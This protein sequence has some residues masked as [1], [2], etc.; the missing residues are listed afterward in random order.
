MKSNLLL[1][2][3]A[4]AKRA[5]CLVALLNFLST[6][7]MAKD[8]DPLF[9]YEIEK[10]IIITGQIT[11]E[12][13]T[14][15]AGVNIM[16]KGTSNGVFSD[17]DGKFSIKV[18][19]KNSSLIF[20]FVGYSIKEIKIGSQSNFNVKLETISKD[21]DDVVVVGYGTQKRSELTNAVV[22]ASGK[23]L[24]KSNSISLSN[25][26]SG[27]LAGVFVNQRSSVP[28]FDDAQ[29]LVRGPNTYRNSSALI[30]IDGV[31]NA[32]PDGLNRLDP[33]DIE[34]ISVLKDASA[35]IYGAQSAGGV[36]LVTTKR[37]KTGKPTFDFVTTQS[38]N[39]PTMK[40]KSADAF[41]YM[42]VLNDRRALEGTPPDFPDELVQEFKTGKRRPE[43]W[44]DALVDPPAK[45]ARYSL[46]MRG[47]TDRVRYFLSLGTANQGGILRG[48]DKTRLK[49]YNVR[50][51]VD[52][53]VTKDLEVGLDISLR[54]KYTQT[55]Q[56]GPGGNIEYFANTSP[57]QEAYIGGDYRYPGEGWSQ[58]NPAARLLSPGYRKY[59]AD[60]ASGTL[61]FKYNIP[62][63]KGLALDGFA[64][65]VKTSNYNKSFN[66]TWFY[67]E[68]NPTT[69]DI[70][71]KPSRTVEDI[72][73][74]EEYYQSQR[75][76]GNLKLS[77][78]TVI[79]KD[80]KISVFA[81]YEQMEYKDNNFWAQRL[82]YDSYM[83][84]Q[85]FAGSKN[86][87][88]GS[89]S[90]TASES[91]RQNYFG[92]ASYE[93][94][95]KYLLGFSA[96]YDGSPIFP[97]D[98]RFGFFPQASAAWVVSKESFM[99]KSP[100]SNLKVRASWGQLGNDRVNPF[101]Y[102]GAFGY[103]PGWVVDGVD[104]SGI[105]ATTT[106]NPNIT[107]E[108]SEK[109]DLGL[110]LGFL[111]NKLTFE[112]DVYRTKTSH[113]LGQRQAS[114]PTYT[115]L[116][117]PDENIGKMDSRGFDFQ[118]GYKTNIGKV[119]MAI[120]G[121][122]SYAENKIIYFDETPQAEP[123]QKLEGKPLNSTLVYKAIGIYRTQE[124][125]DKHP[126]YAGAT[127]GGLI[128]ADLN[129]DGKI[130][131]NDRYMFDATT[132]PKVQFGLN[133]ALS[134][135]DFDLTMLF[136]GQ[137]G[138]KWQLNNSFNSGA[139]GN[140]LQ[141][142]ALNSY[143]L[144]NINSVLPMIAPVGTAGSASDFWY[145]KA[146]WVRMKNLELGYNLPSR[147]LSKVRMSGLRVYFSGD[148]LFMLY[149]NL[150]KYGA[151]DPEFV[152]GN[153]GVYPNMRTLSVGLNITF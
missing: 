27:R 61:R 90:G 89:N 6:A 75:V 84:D 43:N 87:A 22:Q 29:I 82:G 56:A 101:Q 17:K 28:G 145:H 52:V 80:H 41:Q 127:L 3:G 48:D 36:I 8:K 91:S 100:F 107:W 139:G 67:Y 148:N 153:G 16:E 47:G 79:N 39:S 118:A 49:Q 35:A 110:E 111:N 86:P 64:S 9:G 149:N 13:E 71:K 62:F 143:S 116:L 121:N 140:G 85:L 18:K 105:A 51:N 106:P 50:S 144:S 78:N 112:A 69:G 81:S 133:V 66:W 137:S 5:L 76:T 73:L 114:I 94:Q 141:Y 21:L 70:V 95:G 115:G 135:K 119:N 34:S 138:A 19:D 4:K 88:N 45:Q 125:L 131:G 25:S 103:S 98:T 23:E 14:A 97:K 33:N 1:T 102:I 38:F 46:T 42:Q 77:Y 109:T 72:G 65:L 11:G 60:V 129:N 24:K 26:L 44:Y 31:A 74:R 2:T 147:I 152:S 40:I 134:Y 122:V 30:V 130:D 99:M 63:V 108:V 57:L 37:G 136:Q 55:P 124:D 117:L 15:M 150:K 83:I 32:D 59:T 54:E 132:F 10:D 113:I 142:V 58:L 92:R 93:Y 120:N 53:T 146:T 126:Q 7:V 68:K 123:Y 128:F 104:V 20:S 96:R 151:G 12:N